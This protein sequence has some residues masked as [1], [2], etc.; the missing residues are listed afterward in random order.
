VQNKKKTHIFFFAAPKKG[1]KNIGTRF[2]CFMYQMGFKK[3]APFCLEI[4]FCF[5][6]VCILDK[7]RNRKTKC[8]EV[9]QI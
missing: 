8:L 7:T 2:A 1:R 9:A 3:S 5:Q 6:S 4:F